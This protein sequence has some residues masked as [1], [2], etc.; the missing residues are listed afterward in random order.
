[1]E[2][3]TDRKDA[4]LIAAVSGRIDSA[5]AAEFEDV[6]V[7]AIGNGDKAM[8]LDLAALSYISSAGLRA[9][10]LI[11]KRMWKRDAKFA[12]CALSN[13]VDE[14]FKLAGFDKIIEIHPSAPEAIEAATG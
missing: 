13:T 8:V 12:V 1:M 10:L 4:T 6:L 3:T 11:A 14:T 5:T 7:A 2:V 9:I